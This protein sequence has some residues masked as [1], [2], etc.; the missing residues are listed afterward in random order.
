MEE[1]YDFI[2]EFG[3]ADLLA[4]TAVGTVIGQAVGAVYNGLISAGIT[5]EQAQRIVAAGWRAAFR[6]LS[7]MVGNDD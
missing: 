3:G 7:E 1:G 2:K 5:D 4:V 6:S